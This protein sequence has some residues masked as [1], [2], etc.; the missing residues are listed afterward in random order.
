MT[1]KLDKN[2]WNWTYFIVKNLIY[3]SY[4]QVS[5]DKINI[6]LYGKQNNI[7]FDYKYSIKSNEFTYK[8]YSNGCIIKYKN[9]IEYNYDYKKKQI[10]CLVTTQ[11]I[12]ATINMSYNTIN[13]PD[14]S[15]TQRYN[16]IKDNDYYGYIPIFCSL[17]SITYNDII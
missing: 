9:L 8:K 3:G 16:F 17:N 2:N 15:L 1:H 12:L 4:I 11:D 6:Y 10:I 14:T 13:T 5:F 7:L